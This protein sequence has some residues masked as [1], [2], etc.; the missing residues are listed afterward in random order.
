MRIENNYRRRGLLFLITIMLGGLGIL[1]L[2]LG[3]FHLVLITEGLIWGIYALS[4]DLIFGYVGMLSFG[5]SILFG[6]GAYTLLYSFRSGFGPA[7]SLCL[8]LLA[9]GL[10]GLLVGSAVVRVRGAKFFLVT[11]VGS[12]LFYLL[13]LDNRWL[14]GGTDGMIVSTGF[15]GL[16]QNYY[17]VLGISVF[18]VAAT[19]LVVN[20]PLGLIFKMIRD[21]ERRTRLLG[22]RVNK[23][24]VTAFAIGGAIAGLSGGL[25]A[26]TSG[27]V[28]AGFFHWTL[29]ADAVVWTILGGAGTVVG[30][31]V[32]ATLLTFIRDSLSA[33]I[34]SIYPVLVGLLLVLA[35]IVFPRGVFGLVKERVW[36]GRRIDD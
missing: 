31:F 36:N 25:Y 27:F 20:S 7:A 1:P 2:I 10:L 26:Y 13:A 22:Y 21:N 30:P 3:R 32:G 9:G 28:S 14:T 5:Q 18:I 16:T 12:I 11:L 34:G 15:P 4:F 33:V 6:V 17:L 19:L 24:K 8:A 29:S 35:V 23:Y